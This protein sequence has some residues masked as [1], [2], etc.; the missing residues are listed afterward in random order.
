MSAL[1][2]LLA[3]G[4][5]F[6]AIAAASWWL[7]GE[8]IRQGDDPADVVTDVTV[9]ARADGALTINVLVTNPAPTP[10]VA[11]AGTRSVSLLA[12]IAG[13]GRS[14]RRSYSDAFGERLVAVGGRDQATLSWAIT[15]P[16]KRQRL[17]VDVHVWQQGDRLRRH[18]CVLPSSARPCSPAPSTELVR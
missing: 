10:V 13:S 1:L 12:P 8:G 15:A 9:A 11:S 4:A 17:V 14:T 6:T 7:C 3:V 18:R 5:G 2:L 16:G